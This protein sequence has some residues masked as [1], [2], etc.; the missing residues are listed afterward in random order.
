MRFGR[1]SNGIGKRETKKGK[2]FK[3]FKDRVQLRPVFSF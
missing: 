2:D 3:V 1:Y